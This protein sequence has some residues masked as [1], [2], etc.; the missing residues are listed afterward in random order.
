MNEMQEFLAD[1]LAAV[2]ADPPSVAAGIQDRVRAARSGDDIV[3]MGGWTE[4]A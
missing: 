3:M 1:L 2:Q 4:E